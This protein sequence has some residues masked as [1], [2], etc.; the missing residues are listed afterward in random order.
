MNELETWKEKAE[1]HLADSLHYTTSQAYLFETCNLVQ[2]FETEANRTC[3]WVVDENG[4]FDTGCRNKFEFISDG[5]KENHFTYCPY[6]GG[7]LKVA[8]E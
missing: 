1:Q 8:T 6:C 3:K 2:Q 5:P 4:M 7:K